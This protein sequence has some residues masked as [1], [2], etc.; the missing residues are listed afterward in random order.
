MKGAEMERALHLWSQP[1]L[2]VGQTYTGARVQGLW[3]VFAEKGRGGAGT[4]SGDSPPPAATT[5][6]PLL[7]GWPQ[8]FRGHPRRLLRPSLPCNKA[9]NSPP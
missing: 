3:E 2:P 4:G 9:G 7:P 1:G 8:V 5:E 6:F